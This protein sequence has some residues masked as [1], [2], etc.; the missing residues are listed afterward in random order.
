MIQMSWVYFAILV[1]FVSFLS[2]YIYRK[3]TEKKKE[4]I[5][6]MFI[7]PKEPEDRGGVYVGFDK[8]PKEFTDGDIVSMTVKIVRK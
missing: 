2:T 4:T 3:L 1:F 6:T 5:G 7:D 8:D